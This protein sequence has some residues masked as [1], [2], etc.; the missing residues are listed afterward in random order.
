MTIIPHEEIIVEA[1]RK[2][3]VSFPEI[4]IRELLANAMI[5][6]DL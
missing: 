4:A 5:H 6:Q 1:T 2:S 3:I